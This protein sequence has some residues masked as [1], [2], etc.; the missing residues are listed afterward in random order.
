MNSKKF[1]IISIAILVIAIVGS[2]GTYAWIKYNS[3]SDGTDAKVNLGVCTPIINFDGGSSIEGA[4]L[5][6]VLDKANG[7]VKDVSISV[8]KTCDKSV[9]ANLNLKIDKLDAGLKDST[10]VYELFAQ[11]LQGYAS[12]AS[13]NFSSVNEGD[14]ITLF[15]NRPVSL[16]SNENDLYRLYIYLD[17]NQVNK[18]TTQGQSF[19]FSLY[20]SGDNAISDNASAFIRNL[21]DNANTTSV[22][23]NGITYYYDTT[24]NLMKD[25]AGGTRY[26]GANP[27][28]YVYFNCTDYSNQSSDA[29]EVWRIIG[30]FNDKVKIIRNEPLENLAWDQQKNINPNS[31]SYSNNWETA[32]L[33]IFLNGKYYDRGDTES[34]TYY[35]GSSNTTAGAKTT[36]LNLNKIGINDITRTLISKSTWYLGGKIGTVDFSIDGY[37]NAAYNS[38][39]STFVYGSNKVSIEDYVGLMYPSDYGYAANFINCSIYLSIY[40]SC[41]DYN[42]LF[43][44]S[45]QWFLSP[46]YNSEGCVA[47]TLYD[48]NSLTWKGSV[49]AYGSSFSDKKVRPTLYLNSDV[50]FKEGVG[51]GSQSSPYQIEID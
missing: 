8:D 35:S 20:G 47:Y 18:S 41:T 39:R 37:S 24:H 44:P 6:P 50:R 1:M 15:S 27:N 11:T 33:R 13:G 4:N 21:Y 22:V 29:C 16:S 45:Q 34:I 31:N 36:V 23:N 49:N 46:N 9:T 5:K 42:W 10:F 25:I 17:G 12:I 3:T 43:I 40:A 30:V 19:K 14:I 38:E 51:D 2:G 48:N 28:N 7:I 32:S 26:Y